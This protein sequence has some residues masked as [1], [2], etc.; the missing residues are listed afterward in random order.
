MENSSGLHALG[1]VLRD[2]NRDLLR[3]GRRA[4]AVEP[5]PESEAD[6]VRLV[7][8]EPGVSPGQIAAEL[9]MKPSNVSAGLRRLAEAG[10]V[11]RVSDPA[12]RRAA[13]VL[14]TPL[15]VRNALLLERARAGLLEEAL[16]TLPAAHRDAL[17]RAIPAL[18]ALDTALRDRV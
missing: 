18:R 13:R 7:V 16:D 4:A 2:L 3:A 17:L 10:L 8:R 9:R 6:I 14:P 11:E 1:A 12:D 15:A 5:L